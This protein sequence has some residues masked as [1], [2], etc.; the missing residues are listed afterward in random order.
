MNNEK[1]KVVQLRCKR[2][3]R[4]RKKLRGTA[5][6]P[7]MSLHKSNQ[8]LY[9]QLIDDENGLTIAAAST[10]EKKGEKRSIASAEK[11]G[12]QLAEKAKEK[13]ISQVLFDR[14]RFKYHG[15]LAA[16][17]QAAREHGIQC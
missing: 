14:G 11:L 3:M 17:A 16:F 4:V 13:G 12:V 2:A 5:S 10:L 1:E 9:V 8:H 6:R 7:R 15:V